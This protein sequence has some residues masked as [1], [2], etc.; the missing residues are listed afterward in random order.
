[1]RTGDPCKRYLD[2][3]K[4]KL[5]CPRD[6]RGKILSGLE[7]EM[8]EIRSEGPAITMEGLMTQFGTP[9][10]VAQELNGTL[11]TETVETYGRRRARVIRALAVLAAA[12]ALIAIFWFGKYQRSKE[13]GED[14]HMVQGQAV[15]ISDEELWEQI[16]NIPEE[17]RSHLGGK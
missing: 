11:S 15:R 13:V 14:M 8:V 12:L 10:T 3:V 1:M 5:Q 16:E 2:Q 9:E 7:A 17:A 4:R 6:E